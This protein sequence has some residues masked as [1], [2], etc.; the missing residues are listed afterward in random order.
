MDAERMIESLD[1]AIFALESQTTV[2]DRISLLRLQR[3]VRHQ[4]G[5]YRYLETGS[6]LG[7]SLL[8]HLADP[9]CAKVVSID[10]RPA[11]QPDERGTIFRYDDNS[12]ERMIAG[13]R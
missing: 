5:S 12:T 8:P 3:F 9:R 11:S 7:G 6:H 13:C 2:N 1:P 10:P 4:A